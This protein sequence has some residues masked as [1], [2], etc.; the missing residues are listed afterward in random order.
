MLGGV[1]IKHIPNLISFSRILISLTLLIIE[2]F[3]VLFFIVYLLCGISDILD[4]YIA[5]K[6]NLVSRNGQILDSI[7]DFVCIVIFLY[8]FLKLNICP[9]WGMYWI[10]GIAVCRLLALS[11]IFIRFNQFAF[12]HTYANKLTGLLLFCFPIVYLLF[13]ITISM[14]LLCL[15]ASTSALE[16]LIISITSK[17][18]NR[19]IKSMFKK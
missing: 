1:T 3:S 12:L 18:L 19:D 11:I 17:E 13:G 4:G 15:I 2:P 14:V 8:I 7:A 16:E 9:R 10:V 5:R 6:F